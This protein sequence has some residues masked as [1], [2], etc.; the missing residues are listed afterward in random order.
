MK[1][2]RILEK[3]GAAL[4]ELAAERPWRQVSLRDVAQKAGVPLADLY[5][6]ANGKLALLAHVA[7]GLD[8]AALET[9]ATPSED[10]HDRLFDATMARVEAMEPHS[11][12]LTEIA[13]AEGPLPLAPHFPRTARAILEAA[14]VD[15]TPPRL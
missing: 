3:G 11:A 5:E 1:A 7:A 13:R 12:A 6:R 14:G 15:A 10:L 4:M 2:D 9:A 8:R